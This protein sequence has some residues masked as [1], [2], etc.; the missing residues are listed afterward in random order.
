[1]KRKFDSLD[2]VS[3]LNGLVFFAPVALFVRTQAGVSLSQF[4]VLQALLSCVIFLGEI[5]AGYVTDR[6]GYRQS[7]I[8]SQI[9]IFAARTLLTAAFFLKSLPLFVIEV[10]VEGL[11]AC[12]ASGTDSAYIYQI[13]GK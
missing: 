13:Y 10:L 1:M 2:C 5:P 12:F 7:M 4:F 11:G 9:L 6:I 8:L 3:F